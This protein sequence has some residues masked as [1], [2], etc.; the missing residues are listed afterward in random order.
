MV[1]LEVGALLTVKGSRLEAAF[2]DPGLVQPTV[3]LLAS[4]RF[5]AIH[6]LLLGG[7]VIAESS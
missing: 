1:H 5:A 3:L 6:P 7:I 4:L 2:A